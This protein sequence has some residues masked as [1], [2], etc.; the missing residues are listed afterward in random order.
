[1]RLSVLRCCERVV[2]AWWFTRYSGEARQATAPASSNP[3]RPS[4]E[5]SH[6]ES[7]SSQSSRFHSSATQKS[8]RATP[9]LLHALTH[10][11]SRDEN[12]YPSSYSSAYVCIICL[13]HVHI[14]AHSGER[15]MCAVYLINKFLAAPAHTM[16]GL[17]PKSLS[18]ARILT[19]WCYHRC[20]EQ[21]LM[22]KNI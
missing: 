8:I 19:I 7:E 15:I 13:P 11:Q 17:L 16:K 4:E 9:N 21:A 18:R 6:K 2:S 12:V 5:E 14:P 22:W 1:M 20:L 3:F 10:I